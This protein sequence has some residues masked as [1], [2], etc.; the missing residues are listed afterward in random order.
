[1]VYVAAFLAEA[2]TSDSTFDNLAL[3]TRRER[4]QM[5]LLAV[6]L[7]GLAV[8]VSFKLAQSVPPRHIVLASGP[9]FGVYHEYAKRYT[10]LLAKEGVR[11]EERMTSGAA[12]NLRLLLD[13]KSGVDVAF[14][15]GG[16]ADVSSAESLVML[17]TLYYEPL[18]VFY[19]ARQPLSQL[20]ELEGKRIAIGVPGSGTRA[21]ANEMLAANG[22]ASGSGDG[23]TPHRGG[24][25]RGAQGRRGGCRSVRGWRGDTAHPASAA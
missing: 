2:P 21:L 16:V 10:A 17:A 12:E 5:A 1:M 6:V 4:L 7:I 23:D 20:T 19:K 14:L 25:A 11:V 13:P 18:W 22:L 3:L 24:G 9:E 8:F 15:Q